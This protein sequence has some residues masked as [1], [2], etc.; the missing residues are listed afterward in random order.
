M[1]SR[2]IQHMSGIFVFSHGKCLTTV[3]HGEEGLSTEIANAICMNL[4]KLFLG[5][6]LNSDDIWTVQE[7]PLQE[8][9]YPDGRKNTTITPGAGALQISGG[10]VNGYGIVKDSSG[11]IV[12]S[13]AEK[14]LSRVRKAEHDSLFEKLLQRQDDAKRNPDRFL[15]DLYG[16]LDAL[17]AR[18]D[19]KKSKVKSALNYQGFDEDWRCLSEHANNNGLKEGRHPGLMETLRPATQTEKEKCFAASRRLIEAYER[20]S[21]V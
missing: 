8:T 1:G 19:K 3:M 16:I 6:G 11:S 14:L 10:V 17:L 2:D 12:D 9:L 15:V 4:K 20:Y 5:M 21:Q 13:I 18:Y 7:V